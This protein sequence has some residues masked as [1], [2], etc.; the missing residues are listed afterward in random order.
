MPIAIFLRLKNNVNRYF[1]SLE[2]KFRTFRKNIFAVLFLIK[3]FPNSTFSHRT[4]LH[5]SFIFDYRIA[6]PLVIYAIHAKRIAKHI[7]RSRVRE[8]FETTFEISFVYDH[9]ALSSLFLITRIIDWPNNAN[10]KV[11]VLPTSK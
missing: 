1:R 5:L 11:Y 2:K 3:F 4:S 8:M 9:R 7:V 10:L 6:L